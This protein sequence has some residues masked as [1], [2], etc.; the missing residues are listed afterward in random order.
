MRKPWIIPQYWVF[1][2]VDL[3]FHLLFESSPDP[4]QHISSDNRK[5]RRFEARILICYVF[6]PIFLFK[7]SQS[8]NMWILFL[9]KK[10]YLFYTVLKKMHGGRG[11]KKLQYVFIHKCHVISAKKGKFYAKRWETPMSVADVK[12]EIPI[13]VWSLKS[14]ILS[15]TSF[16]TGKTFW[17]VVSA[18]VEQSRRKADMVARG[19]RKFG[20]CRFQDPGRH[21]Q[22]RR[23]ADKCSPGCGDQFLFGW[24][25]LGSGE[26]RYSAIKV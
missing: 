5:I 1:E 21:G 8:G 17:G 12:M 22:A 10:K 7:F 11:H 24:Y 20:P 23:K 14:S 6:L 18:A 2:K 26:C 4:K 3:S 9:D 16:Q 15:S 13:L 19:D 25:L